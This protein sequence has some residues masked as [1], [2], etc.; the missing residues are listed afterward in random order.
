MALLELIDGG[1]GV[2][3]R[4]FRILTA[5]NPRTYRHELAR[6]LLLNE[7]YYVVSQGLVIEAHLLLML[8]EA[9]NEGLKLPVLRKR[10]DSLQRRLC[11]HLLLL[12]KLCSEGILYHAWTRSFGNN[13]RQRRLL[14]IALKGRLKSFHWS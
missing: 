14:L 10:L 7:G 5:A 6:L 12:E 13:G 1:F 4:W 11:L 9:L 8:L 2:G 3:S